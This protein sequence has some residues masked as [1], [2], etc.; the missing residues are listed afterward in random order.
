MAHDVMIQALE[1]A[2]PDSVTIDP[3]VL[4]AHSHDAWPVSVILQKLGR[5]LYRPD[6]VVRPKSTEEVIEVIR[7][8]SSFG[9]PVTPRGLGS[10][11]TGQ[12]LPMHGGIGLDLS[13]L[14]S[15]PTL[16]ETDQIVTVAAGVNGGLLETWLN[17]RGYTLNNFPQSLHRSS[18]GG[19]L[20]TRETGQYSSRYGGIEHLVHGYEVVLADGTV[21]ELV[22]RPRAAMGPDLRSLFI[23]SEG[24]LGVITRVSL[25]VFRQPESRLTQAY[26]FNDLDSALDGVR[27]AFQ[28]GLRPFLVRVYDQDEARHVTDDETFASSLLLI[29]CEGM[30][31]VAIAEQA[32]IEQILALAGGM[33]LGNQLVNRWF[34]K[35]FDFSGVEN[36]LAEPGGY[37]ETIE[38]ANVWSRL[39]PMYT[40]LKTVLSNH[41]DDVWGHFSHVYEQGASVYLI[42]RGHAPDDVSAMERLQSIWADA[43]PVVLRHEGEL[44]HHHG[45]GMARLN[46]VR[47]SV[48]TGFPLLQKLK[49]ALDPDAMFNPGKLELGPKD[50]LT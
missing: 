43:M 9:V 28:K 45:G 44:S 32:E 27:D 16:E 13:A 26:A 6:V 50:S 35:R 46:H 20:A 15:E 22:Q 23:G 5:H 17:E 4:N 14:V 18:V 42:L 19:W 29:G 31:A 48:G 8:A 11:V 37:A 39:M 47:Q 38:V 3:D 12:P 41:A 36:L 30:E 21:A 49:K 34:E 33:P 1:S 10:S 25:K 24:T 40:E 2:V 7:I